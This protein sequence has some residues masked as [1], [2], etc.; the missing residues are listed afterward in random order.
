MADSG[1]MSAAS[2]SIQR[3]T[4]GVP[5][6]FS[7]SAIVATLVLAIAISSWTI[8]HARPPGLMTLSQIEPLS[9]L[10][11]PGKVNTV[12]WG[13][14]WEIQ[15]DHLTALIRGWGN[16][17]KAIFFRQATVAPLPADQADQW[18]RLQALHLST[19]ASQGKWP[20]L[21]L[22]SKQVA[23]L[24][25][26]LNFIPPPPSEKIREELS[27]SFEEYRSE[28]FVWA[29]YPGLVRSMERNLLL[30][31]NQLGEE[32]G[33]DV[34][35]DLL[36]RLA[37][38][39]LALTPIQLAALASEPEPPSVVPDVITL[40]QPFQTTPGGGRRML[41]PG[42]RM[43]GPRPGGPGLGG[44]RLGGPAMGGQRLGRPMAPVANTPLR[45]VANGSGP[46]LVP[47][48]PQSPRAAQLVKTPAIRPT[49]PS[50]RRASAPATRP[51]TNALP[52]GPTN[53]K[54]RMPS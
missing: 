9:S 52:V 30:S 45:G 44:P 10:P 41:G 18:N 21:G 8:A 5:P 39:R 49:R 43:G 3:Q 50:A 47:T 27:A 38:V 28:T 13:S 4:R 53:F 14:T 25:P 1:A 36:D 31:V 15:T 23:R 48:P 11:L 22:T 16:A 20:P 46:P 24:V 19:L 51:A 35:Q 29:N 33:R 34:R 40:I 17:P 37:R 54:I 7:I 12:G 26:L 32:Y 2:R 42:P 6:W